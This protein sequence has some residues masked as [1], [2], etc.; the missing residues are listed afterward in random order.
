MRRTLIAGMIA[1]GA[2]LGLTGCTAADLDAFSAAMA[3]ASYDTTYNN[4]YAPYGTAYSPYGYTPSPYNVNGTW[5]GYNECVSTGS[6]Y[7]CDTNGDGYADM[8]GD[9]SNGTMTSSSLKI[10]GRGE[11]YTWGSDCACWER[12]RA[13][14]GPRTDDDHHHHHGHY[15]D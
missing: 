4:A 8:F 1:A 9:T 6:F 14:D 3:E 11:A 10:N 5:T 12:N 15:R 7:Q 2:G 13:Y